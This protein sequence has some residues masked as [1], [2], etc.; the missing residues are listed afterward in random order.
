[1]DAS[2]KRKYPRLFF[3]VKIDYQKVDANA[4][5]LANTYSK[6]IGG[7][8][9]CM[10]SLEKLE[11]GTGIKLTFTLPDHNKTVE[12][13][14]KVVWV[15]RFSIEDRQNETAY[16]AGIE[17]VDINDKDRALIQTYVLGIM[18]QPS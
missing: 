16:E 1:M 10:F 6:N 11:T 18:K 15:D 17:F 9:I 8:G 4:L 3:N 2:D 13:L 14:G 12:A 7:G 5:P